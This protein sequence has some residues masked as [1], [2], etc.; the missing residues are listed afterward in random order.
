MPLIEVEQGRRIY[1]ERRAGSGVPI[2]LVHGWAVDSRCWTPV[3][4][5]LLRAGVPVITFDHRCCGRSDD[6]FDDVSVQ[7]LADDVVR[8]LDRCEIPRAILNGWSLGGAVAV[9]AAAQL[10]ERSAGLVLTGAATPRYTRRDDFPYGGTAADVQA[11]IAAIDAD[12]A[13]A[14]AN[15]ARAV[16]AAAPDAA[17]LEFV[18][19]M[20]LASS[21]RAYATLLDLATLDQRAL[22]PA[23]AAPA[24]L[25][26]GADDRFVPVDI[27]RFAA[28]SLP[29]AT[30]SV[31]PNCGHAPFLEAPARYADEL[32]AFARNAQAGA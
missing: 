4:P 22:L 9:A 10:R 15:V 12:R 27:A 11:T 24:L 17:Q 2:V 13:G 3:V 21:P 30:L 28:D 7:A 16:F 20:F 32:V 31:Y 26:H 29:A 14:F 25:L 19:S 23:L 6:D 5:A 18:A 1:Y 8:L